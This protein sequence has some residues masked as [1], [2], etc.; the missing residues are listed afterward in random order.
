VTSLRGITIF[1]VIVG[2]LFVAVIVL[3]IGLS[4]RD[5]R[6]KNRCRDDGGTVVE[7][8]CRTI[9]TCTTSNN[10]TICTPSKSCEWRCDGLPAERPPQ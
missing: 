6:A 3:V 10:M 8:D 9:V 5:G 4:I 2:A 1:T 7:Y